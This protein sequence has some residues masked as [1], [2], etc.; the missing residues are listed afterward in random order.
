MR[1][2][3]YRFVGAC[4]FKTALGNRRVDVGYG[5][6]SSARGQGAATAALR[7]LADVAFRSGTTEVLAEVLP[8]N[9]ASLRVVQKAGFVHI[10]ERVDDDNELVTQWVFRLRP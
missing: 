2:D 3:D 8:E 10:G 9:T 4:G 6:A 5:V 7:L 1:N